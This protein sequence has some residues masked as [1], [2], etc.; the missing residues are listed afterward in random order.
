M[1]LDESLNSLA[2]LLSSLFFFLHL[3]RLHFHP[4]EPYLTLSLSPPTP[5][6]MSAPEIQVSSANS[7]ASIEAMHDVAPADQQTLPIEP[8]H[9]KMTLGA[10]GFLMKKMAA[11]G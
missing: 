11:G 2:L 7:P 5:S 3:T 8:G 1:K 10:K 6:T 4:R 9:G